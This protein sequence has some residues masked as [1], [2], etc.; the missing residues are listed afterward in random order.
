MTELGEK[1]LDRRVKYTRMVVTGSFVKLLSEKPMSKI[2]VK[3]ICELAD[4]NRAT[5]Y[6]YYADTYDLLTKIEEEMIADINTYLYGVQYGS[7]G[8]ILEGTLEKIFSYV[9]D[10]AELCNVL[11]SDSSDF[12]FSKKIVEVVQRGYLEAWSTQQPALPKD[13]EYAFTFAAFG[14]IGVIRRWM[15][16]GMKK[17]DREMAM[18]IS[19]MTSRG[20]LA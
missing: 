18:L 4:I 15:N 1:K 12:Q 6:K 16:E 8:S 20:I 9:R 14:S 10:N 13:V 2:T 11:L 17:S 5:F 19:N 3:E 7:T